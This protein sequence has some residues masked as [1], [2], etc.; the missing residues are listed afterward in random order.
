MRLP[1][2]AF[3]AFPPKPRKLSSGAFFIFLFYNGV[4]G[5]AHAGSWERA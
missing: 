1:I 4:P 3:F 5:S 2:A